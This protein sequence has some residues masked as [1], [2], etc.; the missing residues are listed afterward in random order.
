MPTLTFTY[1]GKCPGDHLYIN[2][3]LDGVTRRVLVTTGYD[4]KTARMS[5]DEADAVAEVILRA[6]AR[7]WY[8][9][10]PNGTINQLRTA[11]EAQSWTI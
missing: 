7:G 11:L 5:G 1:Q 8:A 6:F 2:V 10:N 4:L 9:A 3:R